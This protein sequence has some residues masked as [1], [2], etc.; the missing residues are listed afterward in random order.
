M[1]VGDPVEFKKLVRSSVDGE[2]VGYVDVRIG[3]AR[4][5]VRCEDPEQAKKLEGSSLTGAVKKE[6]L[7]DQEEKDYHKR[8]AKDKQEKRSG[9]V[10]VNK[11]KTKTKLIQKA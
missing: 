10:K 7:K 11:V 8:A 9:K 1:G 6:I 2:K 3:Q 4:A 5:Y